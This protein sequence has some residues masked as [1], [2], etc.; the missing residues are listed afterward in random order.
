MFKNDAEYRHSLSLS[1][2]FFPIIAQDAGEE[3]KKETIRM[4]IDCLNKKVNSM[5]SVIILRLVKSC[6]KG[7]GGEEEGMME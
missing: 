1:L 6:T 5:Q 4:Y 2:P 7:Q 3:K